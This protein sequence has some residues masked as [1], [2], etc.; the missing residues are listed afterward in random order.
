MKKE[1]LM[2]GLTLIILSISMITVQS[3]GQ[4][5]AFECL[6]RIAIEANVA[7]GISDNYL[8]EIPLLL[9]YTLHEPI[10]ITNDEELAEIASNGMGTENDPFIISG[11]K[12][13]DLDLAIEVTGTTQYFVIMDC[14]VNSSIQTSKGIIISEIANGTAEIKNNIFQGNHC[15]IRITNSDYLAIH[16]NY[17]IDSF[18]CI[19]FRQSDNIQISENSFSGGSHAIS[20][21]RASFT[22]ISNNSFLTN[23]MSSIEFYST[24]NSTI[25]NN[26]FEQNNGVGSVDN[27]L[28]LRIT[29]NVFNDSIKWGIFLHGYDYISINGTI[30]NNKFYNSGIYFSL[31]KAFE[32]IELDVYN[33]T[34]NDLPLGWLT[35]E[36][37]TTLPDMYGQLIMLNCSNI[38]VE[39]QVISNCSIGIF[40]VECIDI[41][42][43]NNTCVGC[44]EGIKEM[45]SRNIDIY[46]N[47]CLN[48]TETGIYSLKSYIN[49][50]INNNTCNFNGVGIKILDGVNTIIENNTCMNNNIGMELYSSREII[51]I[52]NTL[53]FN[54][55]GVSLTYTVDCE[56]VSNLVVFNDLGIYT[57][58]STNYNLFYKNAFIDN[59]RQASDNGFTNEWCNLEIITGNY[60]SDYSGGGSYKIP[61]KGNAEDY[62]PLNEQ[63][64]AYPGAPFTT[65]DDITLDDEQPINQSKK[66]ELGSSEN[67]FISL[68][69]CFYVL[70]YFK[71]KKKAK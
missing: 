24:L 67:L 18:Y 53:M 5:E 50:K 52:N 27:N 64:I 36:N 7:N 60:W 39:N 43:R 25:H 57:T 26:Y 34:V 37:N 28:N 48:N 1:K 40:L 32:L 51:L 23:R 66:F 62:C 21:L 46:N 56:I 58:Q 55:R 54:I 68:V 65:F 29:D 9:T 71:R 70:V 13:I 15:N 63:M 14:L 20:F 31:A 33:N 19:S 4:S 6:N 47:S 12:F 45:Y 61:G 35:N 41:I 49:V 44:S 8:T 22:L 69:G 10:F 17:M 16:N 59:I 11:W 30:A 2:F 38:I 3:E 42:V